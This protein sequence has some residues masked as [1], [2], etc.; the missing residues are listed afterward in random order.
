LDASGD[1]YNRCCSGDKQNGATKSIISSEIRQ[2]IKIKVH[3]INP[4]F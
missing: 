3:I 4:T 2:M 1:N